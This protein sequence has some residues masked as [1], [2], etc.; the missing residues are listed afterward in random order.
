MAFTAWLVRHAESEGNAGFATARPDSI[1]LTEA[2]HEAARVFARD[3]PETPS[4]IVRSPYL[5]AMQTAAPLVERFP[6]VLT[7]DWPVHEFTF[8]PPAKYE[9]TTQNDRMGA[10]TEYWRKAEANLILGEGA[11]SYSMMMGRVERLLAELRR[12]QPKLAVVVCHGIFIRAV[13]WRLLMPDM[14]NAI[15][16][17]PE[18][19]PYQLA[20][21]TENLSVTKLSCDDS[22]EV[23]ITPPCKL[24]LE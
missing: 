19:R 7:E 14:A 2:G 6:E 24:V 5:R 1:A 20:I 16:R 23:S 22:G 3:F 8:L 21:P 17:M 9:G 18:F 13:V 4:L 15:A 10:V 11:E 12:R